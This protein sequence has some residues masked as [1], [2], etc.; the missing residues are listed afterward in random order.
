M[1]LVLIMSRSR[2][3]NPWL[4]DYSRGPN[5]TKKS[6]RLANKAVRRFNKYLSN[7]NSYKKIYASYNIFDYRCYWDVPSSYRK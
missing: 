4:N 3:K 1:A 7:G 2:S 5:G 6:K